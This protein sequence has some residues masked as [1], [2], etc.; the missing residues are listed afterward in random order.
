[1]DLI[2]MIFDMVRNLSLQGGL[3]QSSVSRQ[4]RVEN[5]CVLSLDRET[6]M[7]GVFLVI[8]EYGAQASEVQ[9]DEPSTE[10]TD[11]RTPRCIGRLLIIR[12]GAVVSLQ[13]YF[14]RVFRSSA[15]MVG[16]A[17]TM[18]PLSSAL[19]R[20]AKSETKPPASRTSRMPAATSH[21]DRPRSQN[22][23]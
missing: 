11:A 9:D 23:S 22:P 5:S 8:P 3:S 15:W 4:N 17:A 20:E 16:L 10:E 13:F 7:A 14:R 18:S 2:R 12:T 21:L 1:M 6:Q 19:S